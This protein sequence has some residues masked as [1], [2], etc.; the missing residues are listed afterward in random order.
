MQLAHPGQILPQLPLLLREAH[1]QTLAFFSF[2]SGSVL[3]RPLSLASRPQV[4]QAFPEAFP[5]IITC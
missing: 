2:I 4:L 5:V 3:H 1:L